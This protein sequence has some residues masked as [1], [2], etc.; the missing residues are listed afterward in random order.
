M[1][2]DLL[3]HGKGI[4]PVCLIHVNQQQFT[5]KANYCFS[6]IFVCLV[7]Q[8]ITGKIDIKLSVDLPMDIELVEPLQESCIWRQ[9]RGAAS[10]ISGIDPESL[11]KVYL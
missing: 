8:F 2:T 1:A 11:E 5:F 9:A 4:D 6:I 7:M 3:P 10:E